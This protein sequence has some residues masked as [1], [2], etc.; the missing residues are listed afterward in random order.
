MPTIC[1]S[2]WAHYENYLGPLKIKSTL[3]D[4]PWPFPHEGKVFEPDLFDLSKQMVE[5][6]NNFKAYAGYYYAQSTKIHND[7]NWDQLT[8]KS[9]S[10]I[11][12]KFSK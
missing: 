2:G 12:K 6:A 4:S 7:Y 1:T 11:F 3:V 10:H 8:N 5:V 9:F